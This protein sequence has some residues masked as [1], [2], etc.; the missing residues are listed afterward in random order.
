MNGDK[1]YFGRYNYTVCVDDNGDMYLDVGWNTREGRSYAADGYDNLTL[2]TA[3]ALPDNGT[4]LTIDSADDADWFKFTLDTVGRRSSYI[5]IEFKQWAGDL[6]LYLYDTDGNQL[7]YA[8][9]I[10]DNE[11]ISLKGLAV[12]DY[13]A[14]VVGYEGNINEYKLVYNLPEPVVLTDDYENGDDKTHSYHLGNSRS[15]SHSMGRSPAAMT[16]ITTYSSSRRKV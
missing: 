8:K 3:T 14:K 10:T 13:Y 2:A 11:R 7:D 4:K 12:G 9:S 6:D 1:E 5:G 16:L 15:R